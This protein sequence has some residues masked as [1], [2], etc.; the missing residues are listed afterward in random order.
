M[1]YL[2]SHGLT[3]LWAKIKATFGGT[4]SVET[5]STTV[6]VK[7]KNLAQTP[8]ALS[9]AT[10]PAATDS[11]A[12]VMTAAE[13]TKLAGISSGAEVNV[14]ADWNQTNASADDYIKNKPVIPSGSTLYDGPG[15]HTDGA[16]TQKATTDAINTAITGTARYKGTLASDSAF[17]GLTGYKVGEYW[18]V[19]TAFQHGTITYD[20][21]NMLICRTDYASSFKDTD[22]DAIQSDI[23]A[24]P[25][26]SINALT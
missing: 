5:A 7:L 4:I 8:T 19:S 6:D 9:T 21:G 26:S 22:F 25:D 20:I 17:R 1:A 3:T 18:I 11:K 14:Q 13:H 23:E 10:L 16:M 15:D 2:D 24:I 12:G